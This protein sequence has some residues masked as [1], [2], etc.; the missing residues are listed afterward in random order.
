[1]YQEKMIFDT[2]TYSKNS[3]T[4]FILNNFSHFTANSSSENERT[5]IEYIT[6]KTTSG[7]T[8]AS[9]MQQ[10]QLSEHR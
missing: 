2:S 5:Y 3:S 1:M 8:F 6:P 7:I 10:L 4:N 9:L